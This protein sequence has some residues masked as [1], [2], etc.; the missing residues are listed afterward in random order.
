MAVAHLPPLMLHVVASSLRCGDP[1]SQLPQGL[2]AIRKLLVAR[3]NCGSQP[4]GDE[5]GTANTNA[6]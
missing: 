4:A 2:M 6:D 3:I 1:T 5:A